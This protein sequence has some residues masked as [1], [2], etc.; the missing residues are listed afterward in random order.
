MDLR[1][2]TVSQ[3]L[4]AIEVEVNTVGFVSEAPEFAIDDSLTDVE[5][6]V[7]VPLRRAQLP[8]ME[9]LIYVSFLG[10][11]SI[12]GRSLEITGKATVDSES[13]EEREYR[14][15]ETFRLPEGAP[16]YLPSPEA[17]ESAEPASVAEVALTVRLSEWG[18]DL[19]S[20]MQ[21]VDF[22]EAGMVVMTA[23]DSQHVILESALQ[24]LRKRPRTLCIETKIYEV[25]TAEMIDGGVLPEGL[26]WAAE[27]EEILVRSSRSGGPSRFDGESERRGGELSA[28]PGLG[29]GKEFEIKSVEHAPAPPS[30]GEELAW[31]GLWMW[32]RPTVHGERI[33]LDFRNELRREVGTRVVDGREQPIH[34][35]KVFGAK[36]GMEPG[37][38]VAS[39]R[40]DSE[41]GKTT[42]TLLSARFA[43]T[44][45]ENPKD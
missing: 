29:G 41:S 15:P 2:M 32:G 3:A 45:S 30:D 26:E 24:L 12:L 5:V 39:L 34:S 11:R 14:L 19:D 43:P 33:V 36:F 37:S 42:L 21:L 31:T 16:D 13:M 28:G 18:I 4:R 20:V 35:A 10:G 25:G 17:K 40:S 1:G 44:L 6:E 8:L 9:T 23:P 27:A 7:R 38:V 22:D